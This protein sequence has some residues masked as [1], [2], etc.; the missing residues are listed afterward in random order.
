M[1]T[2]TRTIHIDQLYTQD[3][4]LSFCNDDRA[5]GYGNKLGVK[6]TPEFLVA[7]EKD[8]FLV[9]VYLDKGIKYYSPFQIFIVAELCQNT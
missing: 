7:C 8:D 3:A 6:I 5:S 1:K 9:P 4:F 2:Q